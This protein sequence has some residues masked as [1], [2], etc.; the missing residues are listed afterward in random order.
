ME[1]RLQIALYIMGLVLSGGTAAATWYVK[2]EVSE[3][4]VLLYQQFE[5]AGRVR[6]ATRQELTDLQRRC[7]VLEEHQR[8]KEV[9]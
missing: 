7:T 2:A 8:Q 5:E 9:K 6:F 4:K 1:A 3:L